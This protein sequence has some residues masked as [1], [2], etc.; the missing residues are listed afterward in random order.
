MKINRLLVHR[1]RRKQHGNVRELTQNQD[2]VEGQP[3]EISTAAE[4][5]GIGSNIPTSQ[6]EIETDNEEPQQEK[7]ILTKILSVYKSSAEILWRA[8]EIHAMKII[9]FVV[10]IVVVQQVSSHNI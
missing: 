8:G 7:S 10:M 9:S 2:E 3:G 5:S 4:R 6:S 1:K